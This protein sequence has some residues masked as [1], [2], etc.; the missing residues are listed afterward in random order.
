[1][2]AGD[3]V[4]RVEVRDDGH[5]GAATTEG[6]GLAGLAERVG[7]VDGRLALSSPAGGPTVAVVDLPFAAG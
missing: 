4:L 1:V 3:G 2:T 7:T 5:G 6:G